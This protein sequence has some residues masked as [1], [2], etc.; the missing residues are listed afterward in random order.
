[1]AVQNSHTIISI[2]MFDTVA[3]VSVIELVVSS[4]GCMSELYTYHHL[5]V[6]SVCRNRKLDILSRSG[7][8]VK[9]SWQ[10]L[11]EPSVGDVFNSHLQ[12]NFSQIPGEAWGIVS[13]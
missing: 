6:S 13:K 7:Q 1:M 3:H 10:S 2:R 11:E 4:F 8:I 5:L 9:V 12:E